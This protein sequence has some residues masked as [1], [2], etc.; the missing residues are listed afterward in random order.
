MKYIVT[1]GAGFLGFHLCKEL[2][3]R[4]HQVICLDNFL[5]GKS[6]LSAPVDSYQIIE[7][8]ITK[9]ILIPCDGVFHLASPTTP[10]DFNKY[11]RQTIESNCEGTYKLLRLARSLKVPFLFTSSIR[12]KDDENNVY[13]MG[14]R[15]GEILTKS[16]GGKIARMGN[17]YGPGMRSDD[18]RV[19]PTFIRKTRAGIPLTIFGDGSQD[20]SFCYVDDMVKGL[21]D[22]MLSKHIGAIEFGGPVH[23]ISELAEEIGK[24]ATIKPSIIYKD[25]P[26]KYKKRTLPYL[27]DAKEKLDWIYTTSLKT[28]IRSMV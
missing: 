13:I 5:I 27:L 14:K 9:E 23:T 20:D 24:G 4:G 12:V 22:F 21:V 11:P 16:F 7:W 15:I 28:G 6:F 10:G 18:S 2:I 26:I 3:K 25:A 17:V 19:I 1:G 8:D